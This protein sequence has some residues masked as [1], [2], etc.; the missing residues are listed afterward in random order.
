MSTASNAIPSTI[1]SDEQRMLQDAV[2]DFAT[3][4]TNL[5]RV[6]ALR[7][8]EP[9]FD[10]NLW[11]SIAEQGWLGILVPEQ[12]GGQGLGFAEMRVVAEGL[13]GALIPE[14]VTACAVLASRALLHG[15]NEALKKKL[16]PQMA[17]GKLI[18]SLA[19]QEGNTGTDVT[20]QVTAAKSGVGY[21]LNGE[22][23]FVTPASGADG[24]IV[25]ASEGGMTGL[26]YVPGG[27]KGL[28]IALEKR[29][30]GTYS[31]KMSFKDVAVAAE[32]VA[33]STKAG[34]AALRRALDEAAIVASVEL[35]AV[36][37]KAL[38][39]TFGYMNTRIQFGKPI[40]SF[41]ALQHRAVDLWI[42]K[43]LASAI[44]DEAVRVADANPDPERLA[45]VA[46]RVKSRCSDAGYDLTR[47]CIRLHGAIGFT[48]DY[49]AGLH[50]QRALV[51]YAWMGNG[52]EHRRRFDAT[53]DRHE[54]KELDSAAIMANIKPA[55]LPGE[56]GERPADTDWNALTD[57]EFRYECI[58]YY[59]KHY[60]K[61][62]RFMMRRPRKADVYDYMKTC[63]EHGWLVPNWPRKWG[64]MELSPA[65]QVIMFEERE[66]I[67]VTRVLEHG[68]NLL[69]PA[70]M[71]FGTEEQKQKYL[72]KIRTVEYIFCQGYSEP[73]AGSDLASLQTKAVLEGDHYVVNGS[74]IWTSLAQD[75]NH[76][77]LLART[78]PEAKRQ[79]GISF[80]ILDLKTPGVTIK[81]ITNITGY[82]EFCQCFFDNVR[83]PKENVVG[84]VNNGWTVAKGLLGFERLNS[85][86][87]RRPQY[88]LNKS[89]EIAEARGQWD[90]PEFRS[91]YTKLELDVSD[92]A[93]L[94]QR[95]ADV[96]S[97]GETPGPGMSMLKI[98][99]S[100][101]TMRLNALMMETAGSSA[102][103]VAEDVSF[104]GK[105]GEV[106]A[107]ILGS[108]YILF[109][110]TIAAGANDIQR[111]ILAKRALG[112]P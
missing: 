21:V 101:S 36:V 45:E 23:R 17:A 12:Y 94:Y 35:Y 110:A 22:K 47:D 14:P 44:V 39:L 75:A 30:D 112:L 81:P 38:T 54:A 26:Y 59:E 28:G 9:G 6:R 98:W 18:V 29:A 67:G 99:S 74:K 66:R 15:D 102:S 95:Y 71:K 25:S 33:A 80:F 37:C 103:L 96:I 55:R 65:K 32:D 51:L 69:G 90:D 106:R 68:L 52:A 58:A 61:H 92:L 83:I 31:G 19:W 86:S 16:L 41:Q 85:G 62:Q 87:P 11:L 104:Q 49:D 88:P 72:P 56:P 57:E 93:L 89:R 97:K 48:D 1:L 7:G 105:E 2:T 84:G 77:F 34:A 27:S 5:K 24:F 4:A 53:R 50:L 10:R 40:G 20:P 108:F 13:G 8:T 100:E 79:A 82:P 111:N 63:S 3:R 107:N 43:E 91:K 60:P 46:S 42:Q 78:D 73:N 64:G 70:L 109:P 76:M